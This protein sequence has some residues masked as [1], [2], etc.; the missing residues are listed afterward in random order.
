MTR[1]TRRKLKQVQ[2][3]TEVKFM[4]VGRVYIHSWKVIG[5]IQFFL[6]LLPDQASF[7]WLT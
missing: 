4:V 5:Q 3:S 6:F 1:V 7:Y 2:F